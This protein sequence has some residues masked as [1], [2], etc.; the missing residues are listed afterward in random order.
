[1]KNRQRRTTIYSMI[2]IAPWVLGFL[3]FTIYPIVMS[4]YYSLTAYTLGSSPRWIGLANWNAMFHDPLFWTALRNTLYYA[5]G[6]VPLQLIV[7]LAIAVLLNAD[8]L[9]RGIFRTIFYLPTVVPTVATSILWIALF[10]PFG[11]V[12]NHALGLMHLPQPLWLQS[13][14]WAMPALILMSAWSVGSTIVIFL[15][16]LQDVPRY[17]YEQA[18]IDGARGW[19]IFRNVTL[20]MISPII[21]FNLI[22]G[23]IGSMQTFTQPFLMTAGGPVNSTLLFSLYVFRNAFQY[24]NMGYAS[25]LAWFLFMV[26][27][28]LT[29]LVL[30]L[31]RKSVFYR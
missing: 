7:A 23:I 18:R 11:G 28:G 9:G 24:L 21:L 6:T 19:H 25:T 2:F 15:A 31:T 26:M 1:M 3:G 20:P 13:P 29:L 17:L 22:L 10:Y 12:I 5:G 4:L 16:G 14:A 27:F 8:I 30:Q